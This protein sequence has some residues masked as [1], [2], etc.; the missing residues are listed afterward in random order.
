CA[1]FPP[2]SV[3]NSNPNAEADGEEQV[4]RR[5]LVALE[6]LA[7]NGLGGGDRADS[8]AKLR[9]PNQ[10]DGSH[11]KK[12]QGFLLQCTLNFRAKPQAFRDGSAKVN[13]VLSFLK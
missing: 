10:F 4:G 13:C 8:K 6:K 5:M 7:D 11:P 9:E 12:L 3:V 2:Q 1:V